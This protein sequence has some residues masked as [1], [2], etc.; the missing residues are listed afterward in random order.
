MN[1]NLIR[2]I[3]LLSIVPLIYI[4]TSLEKALLAGIVL[5]VSSMLVKLA[6]LALDKFV[7]GRFNLYAKLIL[8]AAIIA[9]LSIIL[10]TYFNLDQIFSIYLALILFNVDMMHKDDNKMSVL[11][12]LYTA[13][14][15]FLLLVIIGFLRETLGTG[16]LIIGETSIVLFNSKYAL[17][18]LN[19]AAGGFILAGFL[20]G[21]LNMIPLEKE[22]K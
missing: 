3:S 12:H 2:R 5:F 9:A 22:T 16:A 11:G 8:I 18:F 21:F 7:E 10:S 13:I 20:Y 19:D 4:A 17:S 1:L 6:S 14:S 15:S